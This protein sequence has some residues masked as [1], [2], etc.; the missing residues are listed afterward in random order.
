M[1]GDH[2]RRRL[3]LLASEEIGGGDIP[4]CGRHPVKVAVPLVPLAQS[5]GRGWLPDGQASAR[6]SGSEGGAMEMPQPSAGPLS[7]P[8]EMGDVQ[9][10]CH[11]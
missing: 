2:R 11:G 5:R 10:H 4:A 6:S 7:C 1:G 8:G 9:G 3:F